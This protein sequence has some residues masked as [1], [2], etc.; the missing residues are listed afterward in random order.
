MSTLAQGS[1]HQSRSALE[2]L[3]SEDRRVPGPKKWNIST[4]P[5]PENFEFEEKIRSSQIN[6]VIKVYIVL[7]IQ[8]G[9]QMSPKL[10]ITKLRY[11]FS[12]LSKYNFN[13]EYF[14]PV[15][16]Y[17]MQSRSDIQWLLQSILNYGI[18]TQS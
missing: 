16:T 6:L 15:K 10:I 8:S 14:T 18:N 1:T 3:K 12:A 2:F 5:G 7:S 13:A 9:I 4:V 11:R 17:F